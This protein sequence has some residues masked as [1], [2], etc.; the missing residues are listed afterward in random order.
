[1]RNFLI[2]LLLICLL[3]PFL[4]AQ[5]DSDMPDTLRKKRLNTLI[6]GGSA[7]YTTTMTGLYFLWYAD[8]EQRS[9]H[10]FDDNAQWQQVDKVGHVYSAYHFS[11]ASAEAFRW[12]GMSPRKAAL[13]GSLSGIFLMTP[14]EIFDGFSSNYGAS[15]GDFIANTSGSALLYA[16]HA[17]W[18]EERLH[19]KFSFAP[20]GLASQRPNVLGNSLHTQILKDYNGQTYWLSFDVDRFLPPN[21]AYPKWLSVAFGYGAQDML[22]ARPEENFTQTGLRSYR[23]YY[24]GLDLDLKDIPTKSKFLKKLF[25]FVNMI[26]LPA[27]AVEYN[28]AQGWRWH[29]LK[30]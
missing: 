12:T 9:F 17:L 15:W 6:W 5:V 18:R 20:S 2:S 21:T 28:R 23:Q 30:F 13:W 14:I 19:L 1:M 10:F 22:Y 3:S 26:K 16:Q 25:F 4:R 27:P 8:G 24:L 11:R 29:W 7:F